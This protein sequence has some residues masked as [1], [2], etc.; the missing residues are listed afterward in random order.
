MFVGSNGGVYLASGVM[1]VMLMLMVVMR[2]VMWVIVVVI[3]VIVVV[4][5]GLFH[6]KYIL[7]C[8]CWLG[9]Q[10]FSP[11]ILH[12]VS[13]QSSPGKRLLLLLLLM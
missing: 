13:R 9:A 3:V 10:A 6:R 5:I 12:A 2:V 11:N 4:M 7:R 8:P 1:G